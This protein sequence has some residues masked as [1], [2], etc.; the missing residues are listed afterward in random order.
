MLKTILSHCKPVAQLLPFQSVLHLVSATH[1]EGSAY[2]Y[3]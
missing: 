2:H 1:I 3:V